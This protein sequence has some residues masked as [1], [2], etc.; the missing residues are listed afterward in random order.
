MKQNVTTISDQTLIL[1]HLPSLEIREG[2]IDRLV[3]LYKQMISK[4]DVS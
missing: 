1:K 2:A 3:N 4:S